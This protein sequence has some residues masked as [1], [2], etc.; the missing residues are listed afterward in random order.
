MTTANKVTALRI[1]LIPPF[2]YLMLEFRD[3]GEPWA[4]LSGMVAFGTAAL[5]DGVDG[6]IARRFNQ[7]SE[8]GAILDP[9]ADK[10]LL[11]SAVIVLSLSNDHLHTLPRWFALAILSRDVLA[12]IGLA[13][14]HFTVGRVRL[15][16]RWT[17][18]TATVLQMATVIWTLLH[19]PVTGQTWFAGVA[20]FLTLISGLQYG[21]DGLKRLG[22]SPESAPTP[23]AQDRGPR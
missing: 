4:R 17:G 15:R 19:L 18:K 7:R 1:L 11:V 12:V 14:V 3:S 21:W 22:E 9:L 13:V 16:P 20:A 10:L 8:L 2:I 5:L 6:F 23:G